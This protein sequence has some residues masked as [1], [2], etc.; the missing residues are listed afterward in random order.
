MFLVVLGHSLLQA[1]NNFVSHTSDDDSIEMI[2][3]GQIDEAGAQ[4]KERCLE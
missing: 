1:T 2:A 3:A 4:S